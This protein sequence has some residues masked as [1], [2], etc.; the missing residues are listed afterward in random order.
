V[1][2]TAVVTVRD[3]VL[4]ASNGQPN[5]VFR[6]RRSPVYA[7]AVRPV[8]ERLQEQATTGVLA[9]TAEREQ[10]DDKRQ[11]RELR[12][13]FLLEVVEGRETRP[14]EEVEDFY[15]SGPDD[16]HYVLN[17]TIGE[18]RFGNGEQGRIPIA[19]IN[20]IIARYYRYG[21]GAR[22]NVG[23]GTLTDLQTPVAGV[24][25][26][27]NL[28]P[29]EGGADE[30]LVEDTKARAPKELKARDRAVTAQDFEFLA[31]QTPGVRVRR[32]HALP[33]YHPQFPGIEVPGVVTVIVVPESKEAKPVPSESTMRSV[34]AYLNQ[35]R[36]LTTEVI[37]A[38]PKYKQVAVEATVIVQ[39][40]A[41]PALV[42]SQVEVA[43]TRFLHPLEGGEDGQGWPLGGTVFYSE[44]FQQMLRVEGVDRV[45]EMRLIVDAE[46]MNRCDNAEIPRDYLVFG[47][48]HEISVIFS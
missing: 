28:W 29:A 1:R 41:D 24:G 33:L 39:G 3:E 27:T 9:T 18:I 25:T 16:R 30:E 43:L 2:A 35:R 44:V 13:G 34:C 46:R 36:L 42:K 45:E 31:R 32:A 38:P 37:V 8:E 6:L 17:R 48:D 7:Q 26:V 10:F 5:Q 22:S 15:N 47:E 20:N 23:A 21:G 12:K 40:A 4:G 11:E 19:G 14:W